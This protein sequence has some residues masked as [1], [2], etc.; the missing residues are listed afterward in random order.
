MLRTRETFNQA[1]EM[2]HRR[3]TVYDRA[4]LTKLLAPRSIAVIGASTR[5]GSFGERV[6][7]NL[8][9]YGGRYYPVNARYQMIGDLKCFPNVRDLP[10]V[11]DCAD[12][13]AA[14]EAVEEII[15]DCVKAGVGGAIVFAS[16]YSETG[17]EERIAQQ[18]RLAAVGTQQ[19]VGR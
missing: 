13:T 19:F 2:E 12:I 8:R 18:H 5:A 4:D 1:D 16:G 7:H 17:K 10:E 3:T 15:D 14:R 9:H 11:V 6:L